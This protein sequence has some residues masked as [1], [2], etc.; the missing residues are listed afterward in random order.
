MTRLVVASNN[1]GK[2]RELE[3]MLAPL[4]FD[5]AAQSTLG[6][7]EAEE[8]HETFLENALA[9]ARHA[10]VAT[11]LPSLADDSGLCVPSLAGEPGVHSAHYAGLEGDRATRDARNNAKLVERLRGNADRGAFYYCV[12]VLV[13]APGDPCP[14]VAEG[15]WLGEI[16]AEP[17]GTNGFG[18]DPYFRPRGSRLTAA[19]MAPDEKNR[20]SHRA[21]ALQALAAQLSR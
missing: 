19:Q 10:C 5:P 12:L 2:L 17:A 21:L 18:Y 14:V 4:G 11:G 16:V 20:V 3:A 1:P 7:S 13:R 9:K 15:R 8:P 6:V